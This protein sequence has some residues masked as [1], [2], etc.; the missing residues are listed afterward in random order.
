MLQNEAAERLHKFRREKG[1]LEFESIESSPVVVDG[2]ISD[3]ESVRPDPAKKIIENFMIAANVEM[4]EFLEAHGS[5]S[6]RRIVSTPERWDGIRKVAAE[7]GTSLPTEPDAL[8]LADFLA[9][10]RS[11]DPEHF[12]DL[13]LSIIKLIGSANTSS[14]GPVRFQAAISA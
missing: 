9:D 1:A 10:R 4:A 11:A 6:I 3:I 13:S 2:E 8:A 5:L 7:F 12:P 14:S